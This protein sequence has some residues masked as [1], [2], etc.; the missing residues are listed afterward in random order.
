MALVHETAE[1]GK[2]NAP[3]GE[4]LLIFVKSGYTPDGYITRLADVDIQKKCFREQGKQKEIPKL[5]LPAESFG[6]DEETRKSCCA[7]T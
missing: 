7:G 5:D 4:V 1:E 3:E 2:A 6:M